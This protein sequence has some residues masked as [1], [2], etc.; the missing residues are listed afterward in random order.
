MVIITFTLS[1]NVNF[2]GY[3]ENIFH[4]F[5]SLTFYR[6]V[7][8]IKFYDPIPLVVELGSL[9][10]IQ[11]PGII[12]KKTNKLQI[13]HNAHCKNS[14]DN[15]GDLFVHKQLVSIPVSFLPLSHV[16]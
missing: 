16:G 11:D 3:S 2:M 4:L 9:V 12:I 5:T 1:L 14:L 15:T 6:Q 13:T 8:S 10:D 7:P